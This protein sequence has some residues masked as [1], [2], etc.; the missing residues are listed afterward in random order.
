MRLDPSG[1]LSGDLDGQF[2]LKSGVNLGI[3]EL[4]KPN[5]AYR[6]GLFWILLDPFITAAIY[7]FLMVV[8]RGNFR[9]YSVLLGVLTLQSINRAVSRNMAL[10][11]AVEP[12]PLMH[13]PTR[14]LILSR[15]STDGIQAV[16]IGITGA[17]VVIALEDAPSSLL[18]HLPVTCVALAL[19]GVSIGLIISPSVVIV[20]DI[21]KFVSYLLLASF[22][23]QAV[24][25][26]YDMTTGY[27]RT[28]LSVMPHTLGVE[29][30]RHIVTGDDFPF[31]VFHVAKVSASWLA[32]FLLGLMRANR[33]R[34]RLT[35][36][37]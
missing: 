28:V 9:A 20:R 5:L 6:L 12:F 36:W 8:V 24:L 13:P 3:K 14:P 21:Q 11:L 4:T 26:E 29:W 23:L 18:F 27:H 34:W 2:A 25:Y 31:S 10:N 35:T 33:S 19:S 16:M 37:V 17:L 30:V 22:F 32:I 15:F 1:R 7:A